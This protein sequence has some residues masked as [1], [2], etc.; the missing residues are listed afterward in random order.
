MGKMNNWLKAIHEPIRF[1]LSDYQK[2]VNLIRQRMLRL[3]SADIPQRVSVLT[4]RLREKELDESDSLAESPSEKDLPDELLELFAWITFSAEKHF[5]FKVHDEQILGALAMASGQVAEMPTG[6]GKTLTAVYTAVYHGLFGKGVYV[7]TFNDYLA[8][9]DAAWMQPIY[10]QFG[11]QV[12]CITSSSTQAERKTAYL[13]DITYVT[14]KECGFDTLRDFLAS[15]NER[16]QR[17]P[18]AVIVDEADSLL[19]DE[20][21]I[22]MVIAGEWPDQTFPMDRATR[23]ARQLKLGIH[24]ELEQH[25]QNVVLTDVGQFCIENYYENVDLYLPEHLP[26]LS[27]TYAALHAKELLKRDRDYLVRDGHIL[28]L[29]AFTG[30]VAEK[31][32]WPDTL[33]AAVEAKEG[34]P[35]SR[36]GRILA[37]IPLVFLLHAFPHLSGMT[38]TAQTSAAELFKWY[39][40]EVTVIP[41]HVPSKRIDRPDRIFKTRADKETALVELIT[42][43]HATARPILIGT[44]SVAESERISELLLESNLPHD[45]L[46]AKNDHAEAQILADAGAVGRITLST[47]MAGRGVDILLGG[48]DGRDKTQVLAAGGL[49]VVGACRYESRRIDNQLRGRSARQGDPG[50]TIF[51]CSL[52]D[53]LLQKWQVSAS[54]LRA[55]KSLNARGELLGPHPKTMLD[56]IQRQV[57]GYHEDVRK[58]MIRYAGIVE[59]NR[60]KMIQQM[61]KHENET[62][63]QQ[64]H[65]QLWLNGWA[66]YLDHMAWVKEGIHLV[67]FGNKDPLSEYHRAAGEAFDEMLKTVEEQIAS[68]SEG[69]VTGIFTA[70]D[71]PTST[72]TYLMA[73]TPDAFSIVQTGA[74]GMMMA[75]S[76]PLLLLRDLILMFKGKKNLMK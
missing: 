52:D 73:D 72:W 31:R 14:A 56:A 33:Q 64:A 65:R 26:K 39:G 24:Y 76:A 44:W 50:E 38:G 36:T 2:Q 12:A 18:Y 13:A 69:A 46:N 16:V 20:A 32:Q 6:E 62:Q 28:V 15:G 27:A 17:K 67:A 35:L 68:F 25:A 58:Q 66:N 74:Q 75:F 9:R 8:E 7:L 21:R 43:E 4:Q 37:S 49:L 55:A 57:E 71:R 61:L 63:L 51:F 30:R 19:I 45:I 47:N 53:E 23:I 11:L 3:S 1:Q 29:D 40:L 10:S 48:K 34:L 59:A 41:P 5:P 22:P 60:K 54:F 70:P 42:Q